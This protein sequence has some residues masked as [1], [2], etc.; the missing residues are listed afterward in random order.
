MKD[1]S[2][3]F[4]ED[5][6]RLFIGKWTVRVLFLLKERP[7]RHGQLR[8]RLGSVSQRM[9]TR[10]LRN[11]EA[12]DLISRRGIRSKPITVEYSLTKSGKAFI[13]PLHSVCRWSNRYG[14]G[15][16]ALVP[17]L[18]N[19]GLPLVEAPLAPS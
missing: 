15:L 3:A 6:G 10:T 13:I 5:A 16:N 8:Q 17:F 12:T 11:L 1:K 4:A 2:D 18:E 7:H 14:R 9:L 19:L